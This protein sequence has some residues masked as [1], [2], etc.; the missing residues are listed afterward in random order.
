MQQEFD[1]IG[2]PCLHSGAKILCHLFTFILPGLRFLRTLRLMTV[3]DILQYLNILK[4]STSIRSINFDE[5]Q[6]TRRGRKLA[7]FTSTNKFK[8]ILTNLSFFSTPTHTITQHSMNYTI[9]LLGLVKGKNGKEQGRGFK[10][11]NE[12][13]AKLFCNFAK[14]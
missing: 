7:R 1:N 12:R 13:A 14:I 11:Q 3:P 6:F 9:Y 5:P 4:T 8:V 2:R 10:H